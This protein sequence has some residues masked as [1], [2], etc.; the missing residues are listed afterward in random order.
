MPMRDEER[1]PCLPRKELPE[2]WI[3][4]T[5]AEPLSWSGFRFCLD[6]VG[7]VWIHRA[8]AECTPA[9]KQLIPYVVVKRSGGGIACYRRHCSEDRLHGFYS[10]G[11]GGHI[12]EEDRGGPN[13]TVCEAVKTCLN[14]EI[15]EE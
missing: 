6:G 1:V 9:L 10:V 2:S 8:A 14:R 7:G 5:S 15:S 12:N 3:G 13:G 4:E 11:I